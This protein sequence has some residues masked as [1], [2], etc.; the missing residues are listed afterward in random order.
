MN[1]CQCQNIDGL[2]RVA[3]IKDSYLVEAHGSF[4]T[5]KCI[6][7]A[8]EHGADKVYHKEYQ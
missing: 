1:L 7:C 2:E 8:K 6:D 4:S 3:G 5:A